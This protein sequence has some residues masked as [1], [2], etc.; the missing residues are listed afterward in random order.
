MPLFALCC[1]ITVSTTEQTYQNI[2]SPVDNST[3]IFHD[4][5]GHKDKHVIHEDDETHNGV[6]RNTVMVAG[7]A[8]AAGVVAL[9]PLLFSVVKLLYRSTKVD[10]RPDG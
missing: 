6:F 8:S 9:A 1:N 3:G 2:T 5:K 7:I 4:S 10:P